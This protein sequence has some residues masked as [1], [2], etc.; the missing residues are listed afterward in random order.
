MSALSKSS[1]H[2]SAS[3]MKRTGSQAVIYIDRVRGVRFPV[4]PEREEYE[5]RDF[6]LVGMHDRLKPEKHVHELRHS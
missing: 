6:R 3:A 1:L 2:R 4:M 5:K